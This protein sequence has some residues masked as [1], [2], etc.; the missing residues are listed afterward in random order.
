MLFLCLLN[1]QD[2]HLQLLVLQLF[3][4][5]VLQDVLADKTFFKVSIGSGLDSRVVNNQEVVVAPTAIKSFMVN[6]S[7]I[8]VAIEGSGTKI[9]E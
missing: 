4:I 5:P 7:R 6:A 8:S 9:P 2:L 1:R 3:S